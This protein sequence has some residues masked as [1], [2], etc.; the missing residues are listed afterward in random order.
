MFML[1]KGG[2]E[3]KRGSV[4]VVGV[5]FVMCMLGTAVYAGQGQ[6][7]INT[8]TS[9]E[10]QLLP[11]I[12]QSTAQKIIEFRQANGPF[13]SLD[14]LVKV[15]GIGEAKLG[16]IRSFIKLEGSSDFDPTGMETN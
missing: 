6:I 1:K 12:G 4:F 13:S 10:L 14:D 5:I 8:A 9:E 2:I 16:K 11:G 7:N 15:K 3:M